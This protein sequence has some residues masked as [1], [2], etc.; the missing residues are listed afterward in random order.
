MIYLFTGEFAAAIIFTGIYIYY[1][2]T[3]HSYP[4]IYVL[5]TL[6][7]ILLQGGFYWFIQWR[8]LATRRTVF[9]NLLKL[10]IRLNHVNIIL[11]MIAPLIVVGDILIDKSSDIPIFS[12]TLFVY[13]FAIVEYINYFHMQL[14]N[15]KNRRWKQSSIAKGIEKWRKRK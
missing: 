4:L 15:Y 6:N 13:G 9:P 12:L 8:R 2:S 11:L 3:H 5:F 7:F 10:Y 1:F 14:T